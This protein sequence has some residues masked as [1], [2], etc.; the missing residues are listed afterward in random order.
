MG[1][2]EG[3]VEVEVKDLGLIIV[4]IMGNPQIKIPNEEEEETKIG[5]GVMVIIHNTISNNHMIKTITPTPRTIS[6]YGTASRSA[7]KYDAPTTSLRP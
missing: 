4:T 1:Q 3:E 7:T 2:V 6:L 5:E